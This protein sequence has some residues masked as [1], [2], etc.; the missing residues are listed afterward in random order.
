MG[1]FG[2]S[3]AEREAQQEEAKELLEKI[4]AVKVTTGDLNM[5]YEILKVVFKLGADQG[6]A[7][8]K[9]FGSGGR[10]EAAFD[11]AEALLK[12]QA[13]ELGCD[14]VINTTFDYRVAV[15]DKDVFG[16]RNQVIEV[17][18]YGTAVKTI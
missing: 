4:N 1:L 5:P 15:G 12:E 13:Y 18:A 8:G 6:S 10:P 11:Q 16:G 9:F 3:G 17:F 7:L 2:P 14:W